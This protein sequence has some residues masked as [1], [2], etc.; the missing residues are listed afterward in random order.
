MMPTY[1]YRQT[2]KLML[3]TFGTAAVF[4]AVL[5]AGA[6]PG[7]ER[8]VAGAAVVLRLGD[9]AHTTRLAV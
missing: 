2:G 9:Q 7:S 4:T 3:Y 5:L 6:A 1:K 8:T